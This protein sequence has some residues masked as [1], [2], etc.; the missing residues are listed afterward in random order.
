MT[1]RFP[2]EE[3][4]GLTSQIRRAAVSVMS[5]IAEGSGRRSK[6]EFMRFLNI[7]SGSLCEM[8]AQL[9][10]ASDLKF[11]NSSEADKILAKADRISKMLY[12]LHRSL[13]TKSSSPLTE[14]QVLNTEY[15]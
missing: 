15:V 5:N 1:K 14:Y 2:S 13:S 12:A 6:P 9:L 10:L 8:E 4:W 3:R 7:A 11:V